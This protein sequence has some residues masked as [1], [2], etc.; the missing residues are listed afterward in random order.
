M[1]RRNVGTNVYNMQIQVVGQNTNN[2]SAPL[3]HAID[4][5]YQVRAG[6]PVND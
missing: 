3:L 2:H 6:V 1:L 5:G 4:V